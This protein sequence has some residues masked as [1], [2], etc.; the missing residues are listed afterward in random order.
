MEKTPL[1]ERMALLSAWQDRHDTTL[2]EAQSPHLTSLAGQ[3]MQTP[4][5]VGGWGAC[6]VSGTRSRAAQLSHAQ[7]HTG[8]GV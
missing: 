7:P 4:I 2:W 1:G 8:V 6:G 5:C 3:V